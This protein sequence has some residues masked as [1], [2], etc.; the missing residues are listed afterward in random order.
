[1]AKRYCGPLPTK[2]MIQEVKRQEEELKTL[3]KNK[4]SHCSILQNGQMR[5]RGL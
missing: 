5:R 1:M 2:K 3:E 4:Y